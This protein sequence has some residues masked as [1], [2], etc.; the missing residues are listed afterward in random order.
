MKPVP[1]VQR[2]T[3]TY[4]GGWSRTVSGAPLRLSPP[5]RRRSRLA[6][7]AR[8]PLPRPRVDSAISSRGRE[9]RTRGRAPRGRECACPRLSLGRRDRGEASK[10][11]PAR[12]LDRFELASVERG[13][14]L[15]AGEWSVGVDSTIRSPRLHKD[16]SDSLWCRD[17]RLDGTKD[18]CLSGQV[19]GS[20]GRVIGPLPTTYEFTATST[21]PIQRLSTRI[22]TLREI[23]YNAKLGFEFS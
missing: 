14:M 13:A 19:S 9:C 1:R 6:V 18:N 20:F 15:D 16:H 10:T 4:S 11:S 7:L 12:G 8:R 2:S 17:E 22:S 5:G 3:T 21:F 23:P